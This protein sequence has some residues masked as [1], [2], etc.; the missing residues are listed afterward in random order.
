M[1]P[2]AS[3]PGI[4]VFP[5]VSVSTLAELAVLYGLLVAYGI[6]YEYF[7]AYQLTPLFH[8]DFTTYDALRAP[9]YRLTEFL[10]PL[11]LLPI[12]TRLRSPGQFIVGVLAIFLFVPIPLVFIPLVTETDYWRI[13]ALLWTTFL[14]VSAASSFSLWHRIPTLSELRFRQACYGVFLVIGLGLVYAAVANHM[15]IVSLDKAH[16]ARAETDLSIP[17]AYLLV[18]FS[19]SFGGLLASLGVMFRK[20]YL[21]FFALIGFVICY[22]TLFE[23]SSAITPLW[24]AYIYLAQR[25]IFRTST[26]GYFLTLIAPFAV[27]VVFLILSGANRNSLLYTA[28]TLANYRLYSIPAI[29]FNVYYNYF[30]MH[31]L[32]YWS[33]IN[34]ISKF[35]QFPYEDPLPVLMDK[36]FHMGHYNASF[37]ETDGLAAAGPVAIPFVGAVFGFV[38]LL[39]N[40]CMRGLNITLCA[41]VTAAPGIALI[42]TGMGPALLTNGIGL[43][44]AF[45]LLAP[46]D[47]E[48]NRRYLSPPVR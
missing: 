43:M 28:F 45:L 16:E 17:E 44:A 42:D 1:S 18:G 15:T 31:P 11:A 34:V 2:A 29:A 22:G 38:L 8:D 14:I 39:V 27:G 6:G 5:E 25:F 10:T 40:S 23:R 30:H 13:Y 19:A 3:A 21:A 4:R 46:R 20:Y 48:W 7:F 36:A 26:I 32:T 12:G 47:A 37:I 24:I 9:V 33:H 41:L 35:V